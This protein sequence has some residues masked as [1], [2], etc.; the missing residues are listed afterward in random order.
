MRDKIARG[1]W[2]ISVGYTATSPGRLSQGRQ[3][4]EFLHVLR[5]RAA[6]LVGVEAGE[7]VETLVTEYPPEAAIGWHRDAPRLI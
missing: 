6:A 3:F 4:P 1:G 5:E 7:L 2:R